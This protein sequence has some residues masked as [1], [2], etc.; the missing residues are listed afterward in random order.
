[1]SAFWGGLG[2]GLKNRGRNATLFIIALIGIILI[3]LLANA[4]SHAGLPIVPSALLILATPVVLLVVIA[5]RR[6]WSRNRLRGIDPP[7]SQ[8]EL[9]KARAKLSK[10]AR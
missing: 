9:S 8:D 10:S 1:M 6:I 5:A 7:L 4:V 2:E 3:L